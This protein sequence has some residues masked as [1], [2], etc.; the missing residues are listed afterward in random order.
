MSLKAALAI[1]GFTDEPDLVWLAKAASGR[2]LVVEFGAWRGRS[3]VAMTT[4]KWVV[5]VDTWRGSHEHKDV[6]A[7]GVDLLAEWSKNVAAYNVTGRR[8]DLSCG[9]DRA[10]LIHEFRQRADMVFVDASHDYDSVFRDIETAR[11]LLRPGG[12]LCG[13]DYAAAWPGVQRAVDELVP[14][15]KTSGVIWYEP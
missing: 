5:S 1:K 7:S 12:L 15:R 11:L 13:H 6:L 3:T 8:L 9:S 10:Y 2:D 4:A 14:S